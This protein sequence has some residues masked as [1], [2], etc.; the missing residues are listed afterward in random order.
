V[1]NHSYAEALSSFLGS[2]RPSGGF[3][4]VSQVFETHL[5]T[6]PSKVAGG[7]QSHQNVLNDLFD[8]FS[9]IE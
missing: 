4:L 1:D 5:A 7:A 2:L 9:L 3:P 6:R 8:S